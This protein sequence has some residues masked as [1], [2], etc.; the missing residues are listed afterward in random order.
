MTII[1]VIFVLD[2]YIRVPDFVPYFFREITGCT[3]I[4][5]FFRI[6]FEFGKKFVPSFA[7]SE[8]PE[9]KSFRIALQGIFTPSLFY[10]PQSLSQRLRVFHCFVP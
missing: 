10:Q 9:K 4:P 6:K 7:K 8:N 3:E 5:D 1:I 2:M